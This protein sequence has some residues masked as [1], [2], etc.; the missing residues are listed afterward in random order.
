MWIP[1][2]ADWYRNHYSFLLFNFYKP[3]TFKYQLCMIFF[4]YHAIIELRIKAW[5]QYAESKTYKKRLKWRE[6]KGENTADAITLVSWNFSLCFH[7]ILGHNINVE[8]ENCPN[9]N[10]SN[11]EKRFIGLMKVLHAILLLLREHF[12]QAFIQMKCCSHRFW[13]IQSWFRKV[14]DIEIDID[15]TKEI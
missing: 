3:L 9:K 14:I 5:I 2:V 10:L 13:S 11:K 8:G 1:F 12:Q 15:D 4:F 6:K 7:C